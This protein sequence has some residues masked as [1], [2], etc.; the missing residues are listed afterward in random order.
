M[1]FFGRSSLF[2]RSSRRPKAKQNSRLGMEALEPRVVLA[3]DIAITEFQASN[4]STLLDEDGQAP[5][6]IELQNTTADAVNLDGWF[7]TDDPADLT[8]WELPAVELAGDEY[9]VV[10]ASN[11]DRIDPAGELHTNFQLEASGEYLAL[12]EP[13]GVTLASEFSP[14]YPAQLTDQSYGLAIGRDTQVLVSNNVAATAFVPTNDSLGTSWTE[15]GFDD[16]GWKSGTTAVGFELLEDG[17]GTRDD[18]DGASLGPQWTV[19]NPGTSTFSVSGGRLNVSVPG[20]QNTGAD[21]GLAPFF[22]Q[23]VPEQSSDY[24]IT[25]QVSL[26]SGSGA[27]GII[28][29]DGE[30]NTPAM[31]LQYNRASSFISQVQTAS[32]GD[33]A[34]SAVLFNVSSIY[35]RL[36]RNTFEDSWTSYYKRAEADDWIELTTV[37]EG[38]EDAPQIT[39]PKLGLMARTQQSST[40]PV[41]FDHFEVNVDD[42]Q[43]VY[44]PLT[45]LDLESEM[46]GVNSSV[47]IR[48]PFELSDADRFDEMDLGMSFDD[49]YIAYLNGVEIDSR[50]VP[51]VS[52]WNSSASGS[53][54][55]VD[56][57]L[58]LVVSSVNGFTDLLVNGTNV[59]AF[60]G[61]NVAADDGDFFLTPT[62][63]AAE[64]LSTTA[65][66]FTTATPG[67]DNVLPAAPTPVISEPGGTFIGSK[68][69]SISISDPTP[70]LQIRY[71]IDGT[72]PTENSTLYTGSFSLNRG[73]WLRARTFDASINPNFS[74]S[75]IADESY[76]ALSSSLASTDSNLPILV[77]DSLGQAFP[78]AGAT[79]QVGAAVALFDVDPVSGRA[80][81]ID[82]NMD[83]SGAGGFR[84]RGSST[85]GN[86]KPSLAFETWGADGD[87]QDA[88]LL[89]LP[90]ESDWVLYAPFSFDRTFMH[91]QFIYGLGEDIGQY[92]TRFRTVE[93]YYNAP[94]DGSVSAGDYY[95]VYVLIEKIKQGN[96]RVDVAGS[97][98]AVHLCGA[99]ITTNCV[100]PADPLSDP[101]ESVTGGYVFKIDRADPGIPQLNA[102]GYGLNWVYPNSPADVDSN[103]VR[104]TPA[105]ETYISAYIDEFWSVLSNPNKEI[106]NDPVDGWAK[107]INADSWIDYHLLNI[108]TMNVDAQRL[109]T[110]FNKDAGGK[111]D[112]GPIWDFDRTLE[113]TD[114]R[115]D[116]PNVWRS[117]SGDLGTDF[118]GEAGDGSGGR[119]WRQLFQDPNFFQQY[120]DRYHVLREGEFSTA[121]I[122][123]RI[124]GLV[125]VL[126]EAAP[127]N[128]S[129]WS[130]S[131]PRTGGCFDGCDGTWSGEVE[132][133]RNWLHAR[134]DFMDRTFPFA[135]QVSLD[136]AV[137]PVTPAGV[138]VDAGAV[139]TAVAPDG[140]PQTIVTDTVVLSGVP[141]DVDVRYLV[142]T[143]NSLG[144]S[145]TSP[146]FDDG[147]WDLGT[148][149]LGYENSPAD[150]QDLITT[151]VRPS[152][153]SANANTIMTR[154]EFQADPAAIEELVL[155]VRYDD[156]FVA[157]LNGTEV[158]RS[159]VNG[160]LNWDTAGGS[161]NP[162]GSAVNFADFDISQ[163][164]NLLVNGTNV[165]AVQVVNTGTNSSDLLILPQITSRETTVLPPGSAGGD[166][167]YTL[168]GSDPRALD[169]MPSATAIQ[170]MEGESIVIT[171]NTQVIIRNLDKTDHGPESR[172]PD[173]PGIPT[174]W[175]APITH[176]FIVESAASDLVI[177]EINYNPVGPTEQEAAAL[178]DVGGS[179]FEFV[180]V[181]NAGSTAV[182]L[183]GISISNGVSFDFSTAPMDSIA[184][185]ERLLVVANQE[186][187]E[188]RY[189]LGL[190]IAGVFD[191]GLSNGGERVSL[192]DGI[193]N[194]VFT[195]NYSDASFWPQA[196]DGDGSTLE[197]VDA[198]ATDLLTGDKYYSWRSS[199]EFGGSPGVAGAGP[200]G[201]VVNEV[202]VNTDDS[203]AVSDSIELHNTTDAS[204]DIGGWFLSDSGNFTKFEIPAGT[205]LAAGGY[206][207][208]D[209]ADFNDIVGNPEGAFALSGTEG[210][211]VWL[212]APAGDSIWI[213][214]DV[215]FGGAASLESLGRV[216]NGTGR[217]AP[218]Q[219]NTLGAANSDPRVGPVVISEVNYNPGPA[220]AEVLALYPPLVGGDLEFVELHNPTDAAV[221][222]T[223]WRLRGGVDTT[224]DAGTMIDAGETIVV[225]SF[226]PD[227]LVDNSDRLAAFRAYYGIASNVRLLGGFGGQIGNN[228]DRIE[229]QRAVYPIPTQPLVVAHVTEDEVLFDDL[230]PWG[231]TADGMGD[232][233]QRRTADSYG[234][235]VTSWTAGTASIGFAIF[236]GGPNGDVNSDGRIDG[237]D[238][239][240]VYAAV[241]ANDMGENFDVNQDGQV[242]ATDASFLIE[243]VLG[244]CLGDANLDG[245][246]N[247]AD[248][249]AVGINWQS[250]NNV[251]WAGGDF[252]GDGLVNAADLNNIGINWLKG[253]AQARSPRA[254]LANAIVPTTID[255]ALGDVISESE[256]QT[257]TI[258]EGDDSATRRV[259]RPKYEAT[260]TRRRLG[261]QTEHQVAETTDE[262]QR[263]DD[264]FADLL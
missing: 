39:S 33:N 102:G 57:Q 214:D 40:L 215:H 111:L 253:T 89:G 103:G 209:E 196:A 242:D 228:G 198:S 82:G 94:G 217:L 223:D 131:N 122:D 237:G 230:A 55:A 245:Q 2:S 208:F 130:A 147:G 12:V 126:E 219:A 121:A 216:P 74:A 19:D 24:E 72:E 10:F 194:L 173:G 105:Q 83:Y 166:I 261:S 128:I 7:L 92:T 43:A 188:R 5:D 78:A 60:Q 145:W 37:L 67:A 28:I 49:G 18:F 154:T 129:R 112:F 136:G 210:D 156:G 142:P 162:D 63:S 202:L 115:D 85:G 257:L 152:D 96:D 44:A 201:V 134:L 135:P 181:M 114:N 35:L 6:W 65:Q 132:N 213:V 178:P 46:S 185:G 56:G 45:G 84:R 140:P 133:M 11:K 68:T 119:W 123:A 165:L 163:F 157:Y 36:V 21:R 206:V 42:E 77:I 29:M 234:N 189:G 252:N 205:T 240:A 22:L 183:A 180:E 254:P 246:I 87:D 101:P 191:G 50:N 20:N 61:M 34:G 148:S 146:G 110:Y 255:R 9:L 81:L 97:D 236:E 117:E 158:A 14:E 59:L 176:N 251:G 227:N 184:P 203:A 170:L 38:S 229:L 62:L 13:D 86:A 235:D 69:I 207:V 141:G 25:T 125:D 104:A 171:E 16:S 109:S 211:D 48:V 8:K 247:A 137:L 15:I 232:T 260:K 1:S 179:D 262:L 88:S 259:M 175:S 160:T 108:I 23:D 27:A 212:T 90:S 264:A 99:G 167:Y 195:A 107:Y 168:D 51:N 76:L 159:N 155:Q 248:L 187:F 218:M 238:I 172:S 54:G 169:N 98:T 30:T 233:L 199:R 221:D 174:D 124:D 113:S 116:D 3:S 139:I 127:R 197:L 150:Y 177:S 58:P 256:L 91:E 244:T 93:V 241:A 204:I 100:D 153:V 53:F 250:A 70:S 47:Y 161:S 258:E 41:T 222:L 120:I 193:G 106:A 138:V 263:L 186:A 249:N 243:T 224:F 164:Q 80:Q 71:T 26:T 192:S 144:T 75:N 143:N 239:D 52:T 149:G 4:R 118:F 226:N 95:G 225:V 73:A 182:P 66:T 200:V 64:V 32:N 79:T 220:S 31:S 17:F 151:S 231:T 190:P